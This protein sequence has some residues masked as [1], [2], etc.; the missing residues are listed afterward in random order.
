MFL[1]ESLLW[2]ERIERILH[3]E[4]ARTEDL[5]TIRMR[6]EANAK[7][8]AAKT[9]IYHL[10]NCMSRNVPFASRFRFN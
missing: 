10:V 2:V 1:V 6:K 3:F 4:V 8:F 9:A 7:R 5:E